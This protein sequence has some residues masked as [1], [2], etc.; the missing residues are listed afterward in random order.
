MDVINQ[1]ATLTHTLPGMPYIYQGEEIG[2]TGVV[3][4][5]IDDYQNIA[6][7][8]RYSEE[9]AKGRNPQEVLSSLQPLSRDNSRKMQWNDSTESG[10]TDGV[11]WMRVK[12]YV[13]LNVEMDLRR[14]NSVFR[15]YQELIHLRKTNEALVYG[16][17]KDLLPEHPVIHA[18][19]HHLD[20]DRFM[21]VLNH[22]DEDVVLPLS[23]DFQDM[24]L[25]N[26]SNET[27]TLRPYEARIYKTKNSS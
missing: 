5:S 9:V 19:E 4:D 20:E 8:N 26:V 22:S 17:F 27:D 18:Y 21:I 6:M 23:P 16:D 15:Y 14:E 11:P 12:N 10:F 7:K 3:F 2:M 24:I 25:Q 1:L 13:E